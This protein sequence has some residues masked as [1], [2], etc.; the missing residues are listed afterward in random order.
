MSK[1]IK[2]GRIMTAAA[3][4][5]LCRDENGRAGNAVLA[6]LE[7]QRATQIEFVEQTLSRAESEERDLTTTDKA[8][9]AS[10]R[11]RIRQI[12]EQLTPLQEFEELRNAHRQSSTGY[13][14]T[15][16]GDEN[17][18]GNLGARTEDRDAFEYRTAGHFLADIA[19]ARTGE[20]DA[21]ERLRSAGREL[22]P[23][24]SVE[25]RAAAPWTTTAETTGIL[26]SPIVGQIM[27]DIDGA[28]PFVA[29]LG[30][31]DM[32]GVA[33]KTFSRPVVTGHT[34]VSAQAAEGDAVDGTG[35]F[36]IGGVDFTKGLYGGYGSVSRQDLDW[37]SATVWDGLMAD[38]QAIYGE[39]TEAAAVAAFETALD[40]TGT[41]PSETL[42]PAGASATLSEWIAAL[43]ASAVDIFTATKKLP[44]VL[45]MAVDQWAELSQLIDEAKATSGGS[46]GGTA[47]L[48]TLAGSM[49]DIP[50]IVV[51]DMTAGSSVLGIK[52]WQEVYEDRIGFLSQVQ[53]KTFAVDLAYGGYMA[54]GNLKQGAFCTLLHA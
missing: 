32:S 50:R 42:T 44:A 1:I 8:N 3:N 40:A 28:R 10:A 39:Q 14:P 12:D 11:D 5:G 13:R 16:S 47:G 26:P 54:S 15:T 20:A 34:S 17:Q 22:N 9:L 2:A 38:F 21:I 27:T 35:Q 51:P 19:R 41:G 4:L 29:S 53:A 36:K 23:D 7:E 49:L 48:S 18:R 24:G 25:V 30:A 43:Y 31:K 6:R 46:G 52:R 33:G 37:T 45:W